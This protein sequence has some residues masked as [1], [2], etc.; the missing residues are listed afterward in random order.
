MPKIIPG[1]DPTPIYPCIMIRLV[2]VDAVF[3]GTVFEHRR[4][5]VKYNPSIGNG[6]LR[7]VLI[8]IELLP[9]A[10]I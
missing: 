9:I 5:V 7:M 6:T 2:N 3:K 8:T 1:L 10:K 4:N